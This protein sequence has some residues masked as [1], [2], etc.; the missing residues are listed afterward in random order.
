MA[1]ATQTH[2]LQ[3]VLDFVD[4]YRVHAVFALHLGA[5]G[6]RAMLARAE[7][8]VRRAEAGEQLPGR[9]WREVYREL[10]Y[11]V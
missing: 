5:D 8:L 7:D 4:S 6:Y 9:D 11:D 10:G 1:E 3:P 2:D